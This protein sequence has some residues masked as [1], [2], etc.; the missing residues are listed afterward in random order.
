MF[1]L[2]ETIRIDNGTIKH[3]RQHEERMVLSRKEVWNLDNRIS[4]KEII[5]IPENFRQGI[6]RCNFHYGNE[7]GPVTFQTYIKKPIRSLKLIECNHIDYHLKY[8]DRTILEELLLKKEDS[9]EIIIV[10]NGLITD[11]SISNLIFFDGIQWYTPLKPLLKGTCR[12]RLIKAK[13]IQE[14]EIHVEDL[15]M[16]VGIKLINSMREPDEEIMIPVINVK[17]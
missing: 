1:P 15:K 7:F 17:M 12:Q 6:V 5:N 11:T 3:L 10:K 9:D 13:K 14:A 16:F 2:F 4:L 8:K